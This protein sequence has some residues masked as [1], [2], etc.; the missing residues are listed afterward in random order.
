MAKHPDYEDKRLECEARGPACLAM[1]KKIY[2]KEGGN[3]AFAAMLALQDFPGVSTDTT[4]LA[5]HPSSNDRME[6][7]TAGASRDILARAKK[8]GI[9][10]AGMVHIGGMGRAED[11][12]SWV[13]GK[14]DMIRKA[15]ANGKELTMNGEI[16]KGTEI[17]EKAP[18][19]SV[20]L[21]PELIA[22]CAYA[23]KQANPDCQVKGNELAEMMIDK[24]GYKGS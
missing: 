1:F 8:A 18:R 4:W 16:V 20:P 3:P 5:G 21:A 10:T 22:E 13:E 23:H 2:K 17:E 6:G 24:H 19:K 11:P 12:S 7:M 15:Q 14:A 9:S